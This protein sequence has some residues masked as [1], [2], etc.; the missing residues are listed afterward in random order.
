MKL[1]HIHKYEQNRKRNLHVKLVAM[2]NSDVG[3]VPQ[4]KS[5]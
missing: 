1:N 5:L 4:L 2:K 3:I